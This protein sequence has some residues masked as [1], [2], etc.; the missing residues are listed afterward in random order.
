M[1][2]GGLMSAYAVKP[3]GSWYT[4][5]IKEHEGHYRDAVEEHE[6][7]KKKELVDLRIDY[8]FKQLFG[9]KGNERILIEFLN[10]LLKLP[11]EKQIRE[12][13]L[14]NTE[15][16]KEYAKDKKSILDILV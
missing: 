7:G 13:T 3:A 4:M 15:I 14:L 10:V 5:V 16:L 6:P 8:A 11:L 2:G 9:S 12:V 1:F